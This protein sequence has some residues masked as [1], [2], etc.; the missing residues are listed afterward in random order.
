MGRT[1]GRLTANVL[2]RGSLGIGSSDRQIIAAEL[3]RLLDGGLRE[4]EA[5]AAVG[6]HLIQ[7]NQS[8]ELEEIVLM[9][10][11]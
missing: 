2:V 7:I 9:R 8:L 11:L 10:Q 6:H 4:P 1:D 3:E 5:I